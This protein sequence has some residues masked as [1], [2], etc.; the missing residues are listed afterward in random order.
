MCADF[1]RQATGA[2]SDDNF[3]QWFGSSHV[4]DADGQPLVMYH[5]TVDDFSKFSHE[6]S[7]DGGFHF[8]TTDAANTR[9]RYHGEEDGSGFDPHY[10]PR[11]LPI[12]LSIQNPKRL[13]YD[14]YSEDVW[15]IEIDDAQQAGFDGIVYPNGVEGGESWVA[16]RP[17][18]IKSAIGNSGLYDRTNPDITD[19]IAA[20][21]DAMAYLDGL[22]ARK[23]VRHA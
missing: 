19:R 4:V 9:L 13:T 11:I 3:K 15:A 22:S 21:E 23:A 5:G 6:H 18:Q 12:Y 16:F 10:P 14:P 1:T 8:G 7:F 17:E 20:A 2:Q